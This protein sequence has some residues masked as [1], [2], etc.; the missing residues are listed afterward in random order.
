[1]K[2]VIIGG[3]K[4]GSAIASQLTKEGHNITVVDKNQQIVE[5]ISDTLD[6]M[7]ICGSG[8]GL[9]ILR[10]AGVPE[11]DLLI[12]CTPEDELNMLCC[13]FAKKLGCGNAIARVRTPAYAE[14]IYYFKD[15]LGVSMTINPE[16]NA[17]REMFRLIEIPS[18]LKRD[19]FAKGRVEIV[20]IVPKSG[21]LLDGTRLMDLQKKLKC[22]V[23][24]VA[25]QRDG[26]IVI[27]DG[28]FTLK[29]GDKVSVC[30]PATE[31]VHILRSLGENQKKARN[32]LLIGCGTMSDYLAFLLQK[33]G[34]NV[35]MI[36]S[37]R[38]KAESFAESFPKAIVICA[39]ESNENIL[40]EENAAGMDAVAIMTDNDGENLVLSMYLKS[41]GVPQVLIKL[42]HEEFGKLL[43]DHESSRVINLKSLCADSI[44]RYV[45][46]MQNTD[47][48]SVLTLHHLVDGKAVALEFNVTNRFHHCGK[49][50]MDIHLK[51]NTLLSC[52]NRLG[53]IIIPS[54]SDTLEEGDTV[55]VIAASNRVILDLNDIVAEEGNKS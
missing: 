22:R 53:S 25:V 48:S 16:M 17:A 45:R 49:K 29:A 6:C 20:E 21:D 54:G 50:L 35:R 4:V 32:V 39:D 9:E 2:I 1:M 12:A 7:A 14:Q 19:T 34:V 51:P 23:L 3:G 30:A 46:A 42:D 52:I 38:S 26:D 31:L 44:V 37:N 24:V 10:T 33:S 15:E 27:P 13:V 28:S 8:A 43:P 36:E 47:G 41:I 11:S 18:V 5:R 40:R 55:V